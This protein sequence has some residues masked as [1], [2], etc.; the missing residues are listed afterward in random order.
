LAILFDNHGSLG[1][2]LDAR[3]KINKKDLSLPAG[4]FF[5]VNLLYNA[6]Y[7]STHPP[8]GGLLVV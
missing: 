5:V 4:F 2:C 7:S 8:L 3:E 6:G 1:T